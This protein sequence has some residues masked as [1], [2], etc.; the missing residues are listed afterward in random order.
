[1]TQSERWLHIVKRGGD[2]SDFDRKII[3]EALEENSIRI[4]EGHDEHGHI[5]AW[6]FKDGSA[7]GMHRAPGSDVA[8]LIVMTPEEFAE[9]QK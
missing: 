9:T 2:L 3:G 1:M 6:E 7:L 8:G 4:H 5:K